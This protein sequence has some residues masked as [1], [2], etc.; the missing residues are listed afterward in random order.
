MRQFRAGPRPAVSRLFRLIAVGAIALAAQVPS[1][2][3]LGNFVRPD[4]VN[5]II[6]PRA[7]FVF[8]RPMRK[9]QIHWEG[10]HTSRLGLA[11]SDDGLYS[12]R[13]PSPV[14]YPPLTTRSN[15]SGRAVAKI[16]AYSK[17]PT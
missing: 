16:H 11:E 2:W 17:A 15:E 10:L 12:R 5:P 4:D 3:G 1:K 6:T 13:R 8:F 9:A 7:K 14:L